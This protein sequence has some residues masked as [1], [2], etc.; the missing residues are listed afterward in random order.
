MART[1]ICCADIMI[2]RTENTREQYHSADASQYA[3]AT[4]FHENDPITAPA[5]I[6]HFTPLDIGGPRRY[7]LTAMDMNCS[8]ETF[9]T[10]QRDSKS[11]RFL[12]A[13][14]CTV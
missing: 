6:A 13:S 11:K 5:T 10:R 9:R 7:S 12:V 2:P 4:V 3:L 1:A 8:S 14:D